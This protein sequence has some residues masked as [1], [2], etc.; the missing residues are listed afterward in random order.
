[1]SNAPRAINGSHFPRGTEESSEEHGCTQR[2]QQHGQSGF[3]RVIKTQQNTSP[4]QPWLGSRAGAPAA[5]AL[6][7][8]AVCRRDRGRHITATRTLR[9]KERTGSRRSP[10]P[11]SPPPRYLQRCRQL[12]ACYVKHELVSCLDLEIKGLL[13][14]LYRLRFLPKRLRAQITL[15]DRRGEGPRAVAM[16]CAADFSGKQ[17]NKR[18]VLISI[19]AETQTYSQKCR[20]WVQNKAF[21][22]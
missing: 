20:V 5:A 14:N 18:N 4:R 13:K 15:N 2:I 22:V 7:S 11:A 21:V 3:Q 9:N 8:R 10:S 6:H 16:V 17:A 1:M 19:W 12:S